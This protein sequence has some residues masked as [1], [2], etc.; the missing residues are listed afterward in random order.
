M[1]D[2]PT[3]APTAIAGHRARLGM[4][5]FLATELMFFGPVFWACL[6]LRHEA[7]LAFA[8][9]NRLTDIAIGTANT[10]LLLTSSLAMALAVERTR[11]GAPHGAVAGARRMLALTALLGL[12]FLVLKGVEYHDDWRRG[13]VPGPS[14]HAAG[15]EDQ[16]AAQRFFFAY[17]FAT[18]L[19]A[20]HLA[21]GIALAGVM[22]I[23]LRDAVRCRSKA[24]GTGDGTVH[25]GAGS[26]PE[27]HLVRA[28]EASGLY[29]HFVDIVWI[30]LFPLLYL[31]GRAP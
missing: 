26:K 30:F 25:T 23:R 18:L 28:V 15:V 9:A 31:G 3:C 16:A 12:A 10:L 6:V 29:W 7:P 1:S 21:V 24:T 20:L 5:I 27:G 2:W 14:F 13:L 4:W 17:F 8:Q 11:H 19:H 22:A